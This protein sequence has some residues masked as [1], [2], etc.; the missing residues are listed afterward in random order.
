MNARFRHKAQ[1]IRS[2]WREVLFKT[3]GSA[4]RNSS[5]TITPRIVDRLQVAK[6]PG[7][8]YPLEQFVFIDFQPMNE[9]V[10]HLH[11][12]SIP[13]RSN[14]RRCHSIPYL[15]DAVDVRDEAVHAHFYEHDERATHVLPHLGV[16]V[17]RQEKQVLQTHTTDEGQSL[18]DNQDVQRPAV[19]LH[20]QPNRNQQNNREEH[21]FGAINVRNLVL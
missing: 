16:V 21:F 17:R 18:T 11:R 10:Q 15:D 8:F 12:E 3:R 1:H 6:K 5:S 20:P 14:K 7:S 19:S 4:R 13:R 2:N 9:S